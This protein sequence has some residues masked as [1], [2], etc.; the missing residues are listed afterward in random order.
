MPGS[1]PVSPMIHQLLVRLISEILETPVDVDQTLVAQGLDSVGATE[2][3]EALE[4]H[5]FRADYED[6]LDKATV[7]S[8]TLSLRTKTE[9]GPRAPTD[10]LTNSPVKLTGPQVLWAQ[11]DDQGWGAWANISLCLSMPAAVIPAALLPAMAQSLCEENSAMRLVLVRTGSGERGILQQLVP[12]FQ[13]SVQMREAPKH[14]REAMRCVEAFEGE[15]VSPYKPS[16]RALVLASASPT[17]RH[18]LCITMHH[19]FSDRISLHSLTRKIKDKIAN[20]ASEINE[21]RPLDFLEWA[22]VK[23]QTVRSEEIH[24]KHK[25]LQA[26]LAHVEMSSSPPVPRLANPETF[27]LGDSPAVSSLRPSELDALEALALKLEMTLPLLVHALFSVLVARLTGDTHAASDH[28]DLLMC[29]VVSN[30][31]HDVSLKNMVGCLDTSVPVAVRITRAETLETLC[32][33][34]RQAFVRASKCVTDLPRGAW[35]SRNSFHDDEVSLTNLFER[36]PH[37][38]IVRSP[39]ADPPEW[40]R[41]GIKEHPVRRAQKTRWGLLLR[42]TLP[43]AQR[44]AKIRQRTETD[45]TFGMSLRTFAEDRPLASMAQYGFA[46]FIRELLNQPQDH[47]SGVQIFKLVDRIIKRTQFASTQVKKSAALV[48]HDKDHEPFIYNRLIERQQRWYQHDAQYELRRD[49]ENRFIGT[50]ANPLPFTQLDKLKERRFLEER[51]APL[52]RLLHV[53]PKEGIEQSLVDLAPALPPHFA[54][55]PVGAGH[56]FGVTLVRNGLDISRDGAPFRPAAVAS[57]LS[58]MAERGYCVHEGHTFPFNFSSFLIEELVVDENGYTAPT[59]YKVFMIGSKLLWIQLHFNESGH[60]WVAFVDAAFKLLPKPAWDPTTCWRTHRTLVC[61]EQSMADARK[62]QSLEGILDHSKRLA[63]QMGLFVRLDW[64]ADKMHGPL[65]GEIT[66]F[67]HMLQPR[68]FYTHYANHLVQSAWQDPDGVAPMSADAS[69]ETSLGLIARTENILSGAT[70]ADRG[71]D[72][73]LPRHPHALWASHDNVSYAALRSFIEN[74]DLAPWGINAGDRVAIRVSNG[75]E[76]GALLLAVMN[77]YVAVPMGSSLPPHLVAAQLQESDAR[78]LLV[79]GEPQ[80][81]PEVAQASNTI[82]VIRLTPGRNFALPALPTQPTTLEGTLETQKR[83]FQDE[84]LLLRTSGSTGAPKTV[85]FTLAKLMRSGALIGESLALSPTDLGLSIL[86]LHHVGGITCNLIAPLLAS[87]PMR[88]QTAFDPKAFFEEIHGPEGATWCYLVPTL[89]EMLLQYSADHPEL[90][91]IKPWPRLRACRSAG[92][93]LPHDLALKLSHLFGDAVH[94][95]PTY[96]MT[97]AMP[98]AAPPISYLLDRPGSVGRV[99]PT[100]SVEIVTPGEGAETPILPLGSVGEITVKGPTVFEGYE[101]DS[102]NI[103]TSRGFF[104]TGDLGCLAEDGSGWLSIK[105]RIKEAINRGG[106]TI[107]PLEVEATLREFPGWKDFKDDVQLMVF[108]R[109]HTTLGEEVAVAVAPLS[110]KGLLGPLKAW[111]QPH[112]PDSM[113]PRTLILMSELPRSETGKPLRTRFKQEVDALLAPAEIGLSQTFELEGPPH[114]LTL[115]NEVIAAQPA[116]EISKT[117]AAVSLEAVL[118]VIHTFL[119]KSA[120]VEADTRLDDVGVNSLAAVE[121]SLLLNERFQSQL[122]TWAVSEHPTPRALFSQIEGPEKS[123][124]S[125]E[126]TATSLFQRDFCT[127]IFFEKLK[128]GVTV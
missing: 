71:L 67:P 12:D 91:A 29:H 6:F 114:A 94:I 102:P 121:L 64:Y 89:W 124:V 106:E 66:A 34:T 65:I 59:D 16:T 127:L 126:A 110:A 9:E 14:D 40:D 13:L 28:T 109:T 52:P 62:P 10:G 47:I 101:Q 38:N 56:S 31:Q 3:L 108:G 2:L 75:L 120:G 77:R 97:E 92:A 7:G 21:R 105:G 95:L 78:T 107:A 88:F 43:S 83:D 117:M 73:F 45:E 128:K 68:S 20:E 122:P 54:L 72:L 24:Q 32:L 82:K 80:E 18:W 123:E 41:L 100:V 33:K 103:F 53:L 84:V 15:E 87:S 37:I 57:E 113:L 69:E 4:E 116:G 99:L 17:G 119:G 112:L 86:P 50:P 44:G 96:G 85:G 8:L 30:R 74:F 1:D 111:A 60:N 39:E 27:D 70:T 26:L 25:H 19:I 35:L 58:L 49:P 61:T 93:A 55:K 81:T 125:R 51:E 90:S 46:E 11:L 98:I 76:L 63:S 23:G 118:E 42:V 48:A 22:A 104:R 5:G 79:M 115:I 36:V